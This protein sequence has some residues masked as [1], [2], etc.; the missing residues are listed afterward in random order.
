MASVSLQAGKTRLAIDPLKAHIDARLNDALT[1][2][3]LA[4]IV[5]VSS[6]SLRAHVQE[7]GRN[8][9]TLSPCMGPLLHPN[10][11]WASQR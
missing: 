11:T 10:P 9:V 5:G 3:E 6:F 1:L 8:F 7:R 2:A 4:A